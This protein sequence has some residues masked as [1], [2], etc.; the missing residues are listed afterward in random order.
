MELVDII[1][2]DLTRI[3]TV[4]KQEAH[5]KGLLH[6]TVIA[7]IIRH[8]GDMVLVQQNAHKQDAGQWVS[9]VGGHVA[10]GESFDDALR[11][12]ALEECGISNF[13]YSFKGKAI[14]DRMVKDHSENH[15][16]ILYEISSDAQL[17][18][19]DESVSYKA[20]TPE[21]IKNML[22][23]DPTQFGA[24]FHFVVNTFYPHL[25]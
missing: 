5:A 8:N 19:N 18:L 20:F 12:E 13:K 23:E 3:H 25:K 10:S 16:F 6:A 7:E 22:K 14:Y 4:S 9:P 24:A 17:V 21:E 15:Y 2:H 11:R 1:D